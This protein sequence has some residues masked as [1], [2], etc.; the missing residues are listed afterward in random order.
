MS[1]LQADFPGLTV[2]CI[3]ILYRKV[4]QGSFRRKDGG[5]QIR[6]SNKREERRIHGYFEESTGNTGKNGY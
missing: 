6:N 1:I 3:E 4:F 2:F 5:M